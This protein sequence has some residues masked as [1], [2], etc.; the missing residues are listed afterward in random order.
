MPVLLK[1]GPPL[2]QKQFLALSRLCLLQLL[3]ILPDQ[4]QNHSR[5]KAKSFEPASSFNLGH[6]SC[7]IRISAIQRNPGETVRNDDQQRQGSKQVPDGWADGLEGSP[8]KCISQRQRALELHVFVI[9]SW[10]SQEGSR[11]GY[12]P[13]IRLPKL[14]RTDLGFIDQQAADLYRR[15]LPEDQNSVLI[16][17][18][19]SA[20][21]SNKKDAN[22][23]P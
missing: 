10:I 7:D 2:Q 6:P 4:A 8:W 12:F 20:L 23:G 22:F 15:D 17:T 16:E 9:W 18:D 19:P 14:Q 1:F 3:S 13:E 5:R 11:I 21:G